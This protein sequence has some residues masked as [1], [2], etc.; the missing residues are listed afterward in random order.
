MKI[1]LLTPLKSDEKDHFQGKIKTSLI[2]LEFTNIQRTFY[3][4]RDTTKLL[5]EYQSFI[6]LPFHFI[7]YFL[8]YTEAF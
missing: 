3:E 7:D 4:S 2:F 1:L 8:C 5:F 6:W